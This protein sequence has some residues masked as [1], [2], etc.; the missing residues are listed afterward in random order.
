MSKKFTVTLI[1]LLS[2]ITISIVVLFIILLSGKFRFRFSFNTGH[3]DN[4]VV[5][6]EYDNIEDI[7][8]DTN[9]ADITIKESND[10]K[11]RVVVKGLEDKTNVTLD[12]GN[13]VVKTDIKKCK[14][15]CINNKVAIVDLYLPANYDKNIT[16]DSKYG[17]IKISNFDDMNLKIKSNYGDIEIESINDIKINSN[18]GDIK[19][20]KINNYLDISSDYGDIKI[21]ELIIN[22]NS[23][24]DSSY[25]D[26]KISKTN[27]IR[28]DSKTSFGDN[29][30]YDNNSRSDIS[31]K[32]N[33]SFGDIKIN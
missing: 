1:V 2:I 33:A 24:I 31:L 11:F 20:Q 7:K 21:N 29:K 16:I 10:D 13:L 12:D 14:F 4:V 28:I 26:I 22:E 25:G 9:G 30:V 32:V 18:Y 6:E 23:Y 5:D 8:I 19:I 17:D 15:F 27:D 3:Y